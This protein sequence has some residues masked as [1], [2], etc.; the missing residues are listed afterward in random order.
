MWLFWCNPAIVCHNYVQNDVPNRLP[1]SHVSMVALIQNRLVDET[2]GCDLDWSGKNQASYHQLQV[3]M[4]KKDAHGFAFATFPLD[5]LWAHRA[6]SMLPLLCCAYW[7][8][9]CTNACPVSTTYFKQ[10]G[11]GLWRCPF[12]SPCPPPFPH[13]QPGYD[14]SCAL[15]WGLQQLFIMICITSPIRC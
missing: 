2:P 9:A 14:G 11:R 3:N 8:C 10:F 5:W 13:P 7:K 4:S 1:L 6:T 12:G 15:T